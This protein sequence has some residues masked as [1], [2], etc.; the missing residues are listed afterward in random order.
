MKTWL[1]IKMIYQW[2]QGDL[3]VPGDFEVAGMQP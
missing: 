3:C 1:A 2:F